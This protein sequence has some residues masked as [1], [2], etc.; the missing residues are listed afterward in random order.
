M[1]TG[2]PPSPPSGFAP[3]RKS[4]TTSAMDESARRPSP[5]LRLSLSSQAES[6]SPVGLRRRSSNFS[7][8]SLSEARKTFQSSTDDLLL[9][10]PNAMGSES[11]PD[12]SP[13][14]SAPL[15][16]ALLPAIGGMLFTNG[17]LVMTDIML[18]GLAAIF[19]NWSVRLPW[20]WYH[21]AQLIRLK[22][23]ETGGIYSD[24][25]DDEN[26]L[27]FSQTTLE[28]VPEEEVAESPSPSSKAAR[29]SRAR[30][31]ATKELYT[32]E[33][34]ALLSCFIF[35]LLG[36]YLLHTI[37]S[38]LSRPSEGLVSNYN[39]TIFLLA[40]E[41]RPMAH[42][43]KLIQSRTLHLQRVVAENPY[44]GANSSGTESEK[45]KELFARIEAL[46]VRSLATN[47]PPPNVEL[48]LTGKQS[49]QMTM[50]VRKALQPELDALNRAVRRYEKRATLQTF[51]TESRLQDLESRLNDAISLAAA[52]ANSGQRHRT[53]TGI[54]VEW[55]AT[56]VVLP[57]Q[58]FAAIAGLPF[59][60]MAALINFGK[61]RIVRQVPEKPRRATN[62]KYAAYAKAS[63]EPR[64]SNRLLKR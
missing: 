31:T 55:G 3:I 5:R 48:T 21:S 30:D 6:P 35:P 40:S 61:N 19:L 15:A 56:A 58:A 38:Q 44:T 64:S 43:T 32:H 7:D 60:T 12:S 47:N 49:A 13:W 16:F 50:E 10:K 1:A 36:A 29:P 9:P 37:R 53:F 24:D 39:L 46:E 20:D 17:S 4:A 57:L 14:H 18:L 22:E 26:S 23:E 27:S 54:L 62:G 8:Y 45:S 33:V 2:E 11:S 41:L 59:K 28:E 63:G 34:L 51:Q 25:S 42:L 52:A